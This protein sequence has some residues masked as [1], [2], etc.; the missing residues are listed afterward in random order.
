MARNMMSM[1]GQNGRA[2]LPGEAPVQPEGDASGAAS[3][4]V[5]QHLAVMTLGKTLFFKGELHAEEDI[6][7]FGRV[8]GSIS[9]TGSV[10][11][12]IGGVVVGNVLARAI[13]VKGTVEGDLEASES[14]SVAPSAVVNGDIAAPRVSIVDGAKFNGGIEMVRPVAEAARPASEPAKAY[15]APSADATLSEKAAERVLTGR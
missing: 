15:V 13:T 7:L 5:A 2:G 3:K 11:V 9:H 14:V 6:V 4:Q 10:T 8:E 12:G 1:F